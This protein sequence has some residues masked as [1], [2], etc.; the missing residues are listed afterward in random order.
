MTSPAQDAHDQADTDAPDEADTGAPGTE[1]A[2]TAPDALHPEEPYPEEPYPEAYEQVRFVDVVVP[3]PATNATVL[4]EEVAPPCRLLRI[5]IGL[6]EGAAIAYAAQAIATPRPLT[7]ELF[8]AALE[9]FGLTVDVIRITSVR[10]S[11]F[12]AE[13]VLSGPRGSSTLACRPSDGIAL[14]LRQRL[15]APIMVAP[16]VLEQA[17]IES[18]AE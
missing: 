11:S 2:G 16:E 6:Q 18:P 4:L 3:L 12:T 7:H 8:V 10:Q 15:G 5:P 1:P 17:A 14:A 9:S 13:L